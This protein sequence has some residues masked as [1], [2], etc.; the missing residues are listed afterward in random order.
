M[1]YKQFYDSHLPHEIHKLRESDSSQEIIF[2][3]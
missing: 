3:V 2:N 1:G